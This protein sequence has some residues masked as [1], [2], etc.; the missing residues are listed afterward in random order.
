MAAGGRRGAAA[1]QQ[2][3]LALQPR[4]V[5]CPE[6]LA[7]QLPSR[8]MVHPRAVARSQ[9]AHS[10]CPHFKAICRGAS[11]RVS[12]RAAGERRDE[13]AGVD[14]GGM[15]P[16]VWSLTDHARSW[17]SSLGWSHNGIPSMSWHPACPHHDVEHSHIALP[18]PQS[19]TGGS[20]AECTTGAAAKE[21]M[22]SCHCC[23]DSPAVLARIAAAMPPLGCAERPVAPGIL[24][25]CLW[26][27]HLS[28]GSAGEWC[29]PTTVPRHAG[30]SRGT[31]GARS[32]PAGAA[33]APR[34]RPA[35]ARMWSKAS[36]WGD[37]T[38]SYRQGV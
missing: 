29:R 23:S 26:G 17:P 32:Q 37:W 16:C 5:A 21:L 34:T 9:G 31:A 28:P 13:R 30:S 14:Q 36:S 25:A 15:T 1:P 35:G 27:N 38:R 19:M 18:Q 8:C 2:H 7:G 3:R 20:A 24:Q 33:A 4:Q 6:R 12:M 11:M 22:P 10:T